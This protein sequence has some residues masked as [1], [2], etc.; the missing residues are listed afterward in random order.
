MRN[1][2]KYSF[3]KNF[4][5]AMDGIFEVFKNET[6]FKIEIFFFVVLSAVLIILSIPLWAK[7]LLIGSMFFVLVAEFF[8]S[9]IERVV[10]LVTSKRHPLAKGAKNAAAAGVLFSI[11]FTLFLWIGIFLYLFEKGYF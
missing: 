1:Q 9:S 6:A 2:P 8:N 10:D 5:Y 7:F 4:S 3:F 11:F